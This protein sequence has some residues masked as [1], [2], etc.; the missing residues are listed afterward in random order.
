MQERGRNMS[1]ATTET[2]AE[3]R[4]R[5]NLTW[6]SRLDPEEQ[7]KRDELQMALVAYRS[8]GL[9]SARLRVVECA[10]ALKLAPE[11]ALGKQ[12]RAWR[13]LLLAQGRG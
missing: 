7:R 4:A 10:R 1:D 9:E 2:P 5:L 13:D 6:V 8:C 12:W 11:Q 3:M